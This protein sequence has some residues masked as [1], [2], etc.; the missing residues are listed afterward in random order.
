M[1]ERPGVAQRSW[2]LSTLLF[3]IVDDAPVYWCGIVVVRREKA[4]AG[5]RAGFE[6]ALGGW[7]IWSHAWPPALPRSCAPA[8]LPSC[9]LQ[10]WL[11]GENAQ[12]ENEYVRWVYPEKSQVE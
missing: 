7:L 3:R 9:P 4:G 10:F 12:G 8:L 5:W 11:Q 6:A 1:L 2:A